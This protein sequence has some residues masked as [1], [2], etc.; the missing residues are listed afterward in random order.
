MLTLEQIAQLRDRIADTLLPEKIY[1]F[2][3]YA[4]GTATDDSD[5]DLVVVM[6][7]DSMPHQRNVALKRLFP[8]RNFSLD[9]F[10]FTPQ[11]FARFKNVPGTI[12]YNAVHY[13]KLLYG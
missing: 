11:E 2:G 9:A 12:L 4:L 6:E 7:S 8:L 5:I 1:L 3:S 13:G 10:V